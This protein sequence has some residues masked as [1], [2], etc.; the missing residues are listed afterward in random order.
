MRGYKLT[1]KDGSVKFLA[2]YTVDYQMDRVR[3]LESENVQNTYFD[4]I[5]VEE[6]D[7]SVYKKEVNS[8]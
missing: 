1:F 4:V 6:L 3:T 5:K 7:Y 8:I 2:A